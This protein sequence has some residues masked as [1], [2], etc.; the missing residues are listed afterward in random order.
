[1][2]KG[3]V[4]AL[5]LLVT[6]GG[7]FWPVLAARVS[8]SAAPA[9]AEKVTVS[10][11]SATYQVLPDGHLSATETLDADFSRAPD[12]HGIFRFWD[13]TDPNDP[14]VRHE[15]AITSITMDGREVPYELSWENERRIRVAKIGDPDR[16]VSPG[17]HQYQITY[18]VPGVIAPADAVGGEFA[19]SQS[20]P[21]ES[22]FYW[23]VL[24]QGWSFAMSDVDIRIQLPWPATQ[25]RCTVGTGAGAPCQI[26]GAGTQEVSV[27][28]QDVAAR[29]PITVALGMPGDPPARTTLP[30]TPEFDWTF[31]RS[32]P[33]TVILAVLSAIGLIAG[34]LWNRKAH[35]PPPGFPVMYTPPEGLGPVQTVYMAHETIGSHA[36]VSTLLHQA[37]QGLIRL[38]QQGE[39]EWRIVGQAD[40]QRW[41]EADAV[42]QA[43]GYGLGVTRP[44]AQFV[45][46]KS[47]AAGQRLSKVRSSIG[48]ETKLWARSSGLVVGARMETL[49]KAL[50]IVACVLALVGFLGIAWPTMA[51]LP[52]A[53]FVLGGWGL[54]HPGVGSRRTLPGRE[55]WSRAGGFERLLSTPSSEDRFHFAARKDLYIA[56]IPYATAFGVADKWAQKYQM[57]TGEEPPMPIWLPVAPGYGSHRFA[58]VD[59]FE[60]ALS[61]SIGAYTASQAA[62]SRGGGMGG[63]FSGGGGGGGGGGG[64]W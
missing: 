14:H 38:E 50:V 7:L 57:E 55:Q 64:S 20:S 54:L 47:T 2:R 35:E 45:A 52:A 53:A 62:S 37:E 34:Y 1:V 12:R 23:N 58:G 13:I 9:Q 56:Y 40:P 19:A 11:Y 29:T 18:T 46:E 24:A 39:D 63:G 44:G 49:G 28:A 25:L 61:S 5:L 42:S 60:S 15:P 3:L 6:C 26:G 22:V 21:V 8:D 43:V 16:Y 36:L 51:G 59:S 33:L 41:R 30:W 10:R 27:T 48:P 4:F 32:V 31:G 17:R